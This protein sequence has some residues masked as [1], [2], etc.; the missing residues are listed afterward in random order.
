[1]QILSINKEIC[2]PCNISGTVKERN[3][4]L[5]WHGRWQWSHQW[6]NQSYR[7]TRPLYQAS[8][9]QLEIMIWG[10]CG[11]SYPH[12]LRM[13]ILFTSVLW[14]SVRCAHVRRQPCSPDRAHIVNPWL[15]APRHPAF[16][17]QDIPST[18]NCADIVAARHKLA[19]NNRQWSQ[20]TQPWTSL[21]ITASNGS[22]F[23]AAHR[24]NGYALRVCHQMMMMM[25]MMRQ[26]GCHRST[27]NGH[28]K[29]HH[30]DTDLCRQPLPISFSATFSVPRM[31]LLLPL[32]PGWSTAGDLD[33]VSSN[34]IPELTKSTLHHRYY[35]HTRTAFLS[36]P[37]S[38]YARMYRPELCTCQQSIHRQLLR[39]S[40][41]E[42][43]Y[44]AA[45][46]VV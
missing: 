17:E 14:R 46:A 13:S 12:L 8:A 3:F 23:L 11:T 16:G 42:V 6:P 2:G 36:N 29:L 21:C 31:C 32:H 4:I 22:S 18:F 26:A 28:M 40:W 38:W 24:G 7:A 37:A 41:N 27:E 9:D 45:W 33:I 15:G 35:W 34:Q 39:E 43:C 1:M 25:M 5:G 10:S 30:G 44:V 19:S 20:T